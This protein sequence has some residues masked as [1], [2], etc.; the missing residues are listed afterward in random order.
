VSS[1]RDAA[2]VQAYLLRLGPAAALEP[3][4]AR[5]TAALDAAGVPYALRDRDLDA[6]TVAIVIDPDRDGL[7]E[8]LSAI[9]DARYHAPAV[10]VK[11]ALVAR[12]TL[13]VVDLET[14]WRID[15]VIRPLTTARLPSSRP[16][17]G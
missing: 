13:H 9:G 6:R 14:A 7:F 17:P 15:L 11:D 10:R 4:L 2:R 8:L 5:I 3:T 16:S 12:A 1:E